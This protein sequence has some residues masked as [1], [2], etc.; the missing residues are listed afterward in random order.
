MYYSIIA[1]P[2]RHKAQEWRKINVFD[3]L[4]CA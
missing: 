2:D 4:N 3:D 1:A